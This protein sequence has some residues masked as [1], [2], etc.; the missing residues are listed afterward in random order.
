MAYKVPL[1]DL[2]YTRDEE[3]AVLGV[4]RSGWISMGPKTR[5]LEERFAAHVGAK[6][7]VAL[8][9][10]TAALHLA[11][12]A[13]GVGEGDEVIVPS[14][15]FVATVNSIRYVRATP[16]FAEIK[17][18]QDLSLD[19]DDVRRR[20]TPRTRAILAVHYAGF[21][22]DMDALRKIAREHS[23]YLIE[24]AAH[25]PASLHDGRHLGA[26]GDVGCFSFFSNKNMTCAEGGMLVT[27]NEE[28]AGRAR[29][30]R[31]HGMTTVSYDRA[32]GHAADYDVVEEGFNYRLDDL[33]ASLAL[34][35][36]DKLEADVKRRRDF[37]NRYIEALR[38]LNT[39]Q[40]PFLDHPHP[41][42]H[43]IFPVL[44]GEGGRTRRDQVREI[45]AARGIQTSVHYPAAHRL[46]IFQPFATPL[47]RTE[48]VADHEITLPL[49]GSMQPS[50]IEY[51]IENLAQAL[52]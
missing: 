27:D 37:R 51:V 38:G 52:S 8:S 11:L 18:S 33:R 1:F 26:L 47:P 43:Y 32:R 34:V 19:P 41:S 4:I 49:H 35:Q 15:T 22:C 46:S 17:G 13:L 25:A 3:E 31:S 45:L 12:A 9:S 50:E 2:N 29:L 5:E 44:L 10:G 20:I 30:M 6:H 48:H 39:I 14:L 7:A 16:V 40:L 28:V 42:S 24:D 21:A 23:L 36:L